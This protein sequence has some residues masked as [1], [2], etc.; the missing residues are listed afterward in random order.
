MSKKKNHKLLIDFG[1]VNLDS[2]FYQIPLKKEWMEQLARHSKDTLTK[3]LEGDSIKEGKDQDDLPY[4]YLE[5]E[6]KHGFTVAELNSSAD[7]ANDYLPLFYGLS[8]ELLKSGYSSDVVQ[9]LI[10]EPENWDQLNPDQVKKA[11]EIFNGFLKAQKNPLALVTLMFNRFCPFWTEK[12]TQHLTQEFFQAILEFAN[13]EE[14]GWKE[15]DAEEVGEESNSPA[16]IA[17]VS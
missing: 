1:L 7:A 16:T 9:S 12:D 3:L 14:S 10:L 13:K 17:I 5:L 4:W 15:V 2:E 8:R 6:K 11:S